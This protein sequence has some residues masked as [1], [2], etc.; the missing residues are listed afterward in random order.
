MKV[1]YLKMMS[2][3]KLLQQGTQTH[4][5]RINTHYNYECSSN[6]SRSKQNKSQKGMYIVSLHIC[7]Y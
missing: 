4:S 7:Y 2:N 3:T 6:G 1:Y 5:F